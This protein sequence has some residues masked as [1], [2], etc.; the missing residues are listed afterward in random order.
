MRNV[1]LELSTRRR[2]H[3]ST[4][5]SS[6]TSLK[7]GNLMKHN[8]FWA[9]LGKALA[10][11]TAMLIVT[12]MLVPAAT[13]QSKYKV[14]HRFYQVDQQ[15][16]DGT[17]PYGGLI[18]DAAGNLYG[19][20]AYGWGSG[21][22]W[23]GCGS[24][25]KLTPN[26]DGSWAE[27]VLTDSFF[28]TDPGSWSMA[29]LTFDGHG[30]LY[31]TTTGDYQCCGQVL[32]GAPNPDGTWTWKTLYSFTGGRDGARPYAGLIFDA[33][34]DLYGTTTG[35]GPYGYGVVFKLTP[36]PDGT[37]TESALYNFTGGKDG[38]NPYAGLVLDSAGNLYGT[39]AG[40]GFAGC[41][42]AC[43]LVFQL[44]PSGSQW[45]EKVLHRFSGGKDGG[46]PS[47][48]VIFDAAGNLYSTTVSGG[49]YGLGVVFE[50][51]PNSTGGWKE[52]VLHQFQGGK[53][54]ANPYAALVFDTAGNLYGT[55]YNGGAPGY[56]TVYKLTLGTDGK[57]R[58]HV[59]RAFRGHPL[60]NPYAGLTL[61]SAGNLYGTTAGGDQDCSY[62]IN[63][64]GA[65]Y[66]ITP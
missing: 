47:A 33:P 28:N 55:T 19:I 38:A 24:V 32:K 62:W 9:A 37:W 45:K 48:N 54:G 61:D 16:Y 46:T 13:A 5:F 22:Y 12:L 50:L 17:S 20:T 1:K 15:H 23:H 40:G 27:S 7:G 43:G 26:P 57:W 39:A 29:E 59:L 10:A 18:L 30:N 25:F 41:G 63:D 34:G 60:R 56:G 42:S 51:I 4:W 36:N 66:E 3:F 44:T 64:C 21:C 53:D 6:T 2:I 65:V 58:E 14:L 11:V 8:K 52:K 49:A 35:G 31:G